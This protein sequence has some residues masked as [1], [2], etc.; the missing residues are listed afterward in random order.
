MVWRFMVREEEEEEE[1]GGSCLIHRESQ[2]GREAEAADAW[3]QLG[4]S[5]A[6]RRTGV[7]GGGERGRRVSKEGGEVKG[8]E[9]GRKISIWSG[10]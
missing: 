9:Q 7:G 6:A 5:W 3:L 8:E 2:I 10:R 4:G 1:G